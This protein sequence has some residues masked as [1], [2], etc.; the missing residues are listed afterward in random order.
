M[1]TADIADASRVSHSYSKHPILAYS[2]ANANSPPECLAPH[3][4]V[5]A[6][7]N[8]ANSARLRLF[9]HERTGFNNGKTSRTIVTAVKIASTNRE[10]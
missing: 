8:E 10:S 3:G 6:I 5:L 7:N 2:R 9:G 1:S 4:R